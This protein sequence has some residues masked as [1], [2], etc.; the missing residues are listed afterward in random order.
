[1]HSLAGEIPDSFGYLVNLEVLNLERNKLTG[2][3]KSGHTS[4][5][6]FVHCIFNRDNSR[7]FR[8]SRSVGGLES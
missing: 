8:E 7:F 6:T 4:T 5:T 1:M 2:V 3:L